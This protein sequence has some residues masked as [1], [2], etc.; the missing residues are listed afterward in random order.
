MS[1]TP[2][3]AVLAEGAMAR[4]EELRSVLERRGFD[5]RIMAPPDAKANA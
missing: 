5:A 3:I 1:D 2:E 4:L